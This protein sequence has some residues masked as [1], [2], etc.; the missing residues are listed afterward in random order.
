ME[1]LLERLKANFDDADGW[2]RIVDADW[3]FDDL[4]ISLS[5]NFND[6]Q[7]TELWEID[8]NGVIEE[9]ICSKSTGTLTLSSDSSLLKPF[10]EP[11]VQ[12]VFSENALDPALLLGVVCSCCAETLGRTTYI[13]RFMNLNPTIN[14]IVSSKFGSLG[15]FPESVA[16]SI[17][18]VL[19]EQPIKIS[20][21][22]GHMPK[23]WTGTEFVSHPTLM[24]L[25]IGES[26]VIG[27]QFF[28]SRA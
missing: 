2:I 27:S 12:V 26:Y 20:K 3:F 28:A 5:I 19:K 22:A 15:R 24:A 17:L 8:C 6:G 21:L 11:E 1:E 4:K 14:G 25:S 10:V 23:R 7:P 9:S 13:S 18:A 16:N